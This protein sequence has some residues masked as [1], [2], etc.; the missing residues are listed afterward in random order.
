MANGQFTL[1]EMTQKILEAL[2]SDEVNSISD[3]VEAYQV[4][5]LL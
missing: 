2:G 3:T 4:A 5:R 1:L